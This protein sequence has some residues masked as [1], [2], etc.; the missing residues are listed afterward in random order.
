MDFSW[1]KVVAISMGEL[2]GDDLIEEGLD[3]LEVGHVT[4]GT[5]DSRGADGV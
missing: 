3:R 1:T 4:G 2:V 5:D